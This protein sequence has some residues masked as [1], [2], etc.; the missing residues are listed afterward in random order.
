MSK[1]QLEE[2]RRLV[3]ADGRKDFE[4]A[5]RGARQ[6]SGSAGIEIPFPTS[7][8]LFHDQSEDIDGDRR[9]RPEGWP[10][11]PDEDA[12]RP[13]H[14]KPQDRSKLSGRC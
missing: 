10:V 1:D 14:S 3:A 7:V 11:Q 9:K 6:A 13:M 2:V 8:V 5:N 12:P 4:F